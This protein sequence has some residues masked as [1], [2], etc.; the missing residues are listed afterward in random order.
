MGVWNPRLRKNT[1][2]SGNLQV[3]GPFFCSK[4]SKDEGFR[5]VTRIDRTVAFLKVIH[6][7]SHRLLITFGDIL[8]GLLLKARFLSH[9]II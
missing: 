8:I 9:Y 4:V 6:K 3:F 1:C 7:V 5:L 2:I